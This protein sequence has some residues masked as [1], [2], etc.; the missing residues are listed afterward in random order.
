MDFDRLADSLFGLQQIIGCPIS[1]LDLA[2]LRQLVAARVEETDRLDFKRE[3]GSGGRASETLAKDIAA[4]ANHLGGLL[5]IG[6]DEDR[7]SSGSVAHQLIPIPANVGSESQIDWAMKQ[8][9]ARVVPR[10]DVALRWIGEPGD[11]STGY[12]IVGVPR[13][14][15]QP[16]A[17]DLRDGKFMY[18]RR[19]GTHNTQMTESEIASAY[20]E[21]DRSAAALRERFEVLVH[22]SQ[23]PSSQLSTISIATVLVPE[24]PGDWT[25]NGSSLKASEQWL[26]SAPYALD[27]FDLIDRI[28][29]PDP[30]HQ[31]TR[32][33]Y[34]SVQHQLPSDGYFE[35][36]GDGAS[37]VRTALSAVPC[38]G[39]RDGRAEF[40]ISDLRF[41]ARLRSHLRWAA[42]HAIDRSGTFGNALCGVNVMV[43]VP[44]DLTATMDLGR[45]HEPIGDAHLPIA[46]TT[47]VSR[48]LRIEDVAEGDRTTSKVT[49]LLLDD[50]HQK[51]LGSPACTLLD[52]RGRYV[53]EAMDEP[54]GSNLSGDRGDSTLELVDMNGESFATVIEEPS[55]SWTLTAGD[56]STSLASEESAR[57]TAGAWLRSRLLAGR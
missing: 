53:L 6:V 2:A 4:M 36:H 20:S 57:E 19:R 11:D 37:V 44:I 35:F 50:F 25:I 28:G 21:R 38:D 52:E 14:S 54:I 32:A 47:A 49:A 17:A 22:S 55:G 34:R 16:Y 3:L 5:I 42:A 18:Q 48:L 8:I 15:R 23:L 24:Q 56:S 33:G 31:R 30:I 26:D 51:W 12:L 39:Q 40:Q 46:Q 10:V 13:G 27:S 43:S 41:F 9:A 7:T 29:L 1:E 45:V